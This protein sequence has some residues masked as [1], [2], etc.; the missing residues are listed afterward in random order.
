MAQAL[1][2]SKKCSGQLICGGVVHQLTLHGPYGG[3]GGTSWND[4]TTHNGV[5]KIIL[6]Y[7]KGE[8]GGIGT[9]SVIYSDG[10]K[11]EHKSGDNTYTQV[12]IELDPGEVIEKLSGYTGAVPGALTTA[13]VV[14]SLT[15]K[16]NQDTYSYG[17]KEG[18]A[19][20][21]PTIPDDSTIAGFVGRT[22]GDYLNAIGLYEK[23]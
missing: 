1:K 10:T 13:E 11:T 7:K 15:I 23:S 5:R 2:V 21:T 19:F 18:N 6:S 8:S 17:V 16:T 22:S 14:R 4:G 3:N 20:S 12:T 9:F